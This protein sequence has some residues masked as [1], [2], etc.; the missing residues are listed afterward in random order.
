[1]DIWRAFLKKHKPAHR[2][3]AFLLYTYA[4]Y[5]KNEEQVN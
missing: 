2:V 5:V 3:P 4:G 1:M